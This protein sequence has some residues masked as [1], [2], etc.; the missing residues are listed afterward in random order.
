MR[1]GFFITGIGTEVGKTVA[2]AVMVRALNALYWKP[3]Q[4]GDLQD[5]DTDKVVRLTGCRSHPERYRLQLP[6]S[7]HAAAAAEGIGIQVSDFQLP[8]CEGHL[9]VEGA[10]GV[11][12][13]LNDH[14]TMLDL[15]VRLALPVIVVSRH[16]L[17][18]INHTLLTVSALRSQGVAV[19]GVL[20]NGD[21]NE[22][23][24]SVILGMSGLPSLGRIPVMEV[25][26]TES[27]ESVAHGI[28]A[29][30]R[31]LGII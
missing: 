26:T 21:Q 19:A 20:F 7:P 10:G 29:H 28:G 25:L 27:V 24:E 13:P 6:M 16:Y 14:D 3:V 8:E 9:I 2:S 15:M 11:L 22:E 4:A 30:I 1:K 5:T 23:T 18:S 17:G 31:S 12:V